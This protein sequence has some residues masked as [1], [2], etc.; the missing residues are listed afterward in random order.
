[1]VASASNTHLEDDGKVHL[2]AGVRDTTYLPTGNAEVTAHVVA[3][4]GAAEDISLKPDPLKQGEYS[5]DF[6]ATKSGSYV[7][8]FSATENNKPLGKDILTL[9]RQDGVA[10]NFHREQNA[11]LL[12]KLSN[13]TGG[14]YYTPSD[15]ANLPREIAYSEAGISSREMKDLWDMP[16]VF[17]LLLIFKSS[18]WLLRRKWGVV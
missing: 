15:A 5:A 17:L 1:V 4:D 3:P 18:E 7:A 12:K 6:D 10:E 13:E 9:Q 16:A 11:D 8:E 14:R 2:H